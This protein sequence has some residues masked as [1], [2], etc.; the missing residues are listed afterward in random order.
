[1]CL[2]I[3]L[4]EVV[5]DWPLVIAANREEHYDRPGE[6]PRLLCESPL[7]FG[8]RDPRA[9]GT[10]LA[11]NQWAMVCAVTNRPRTEMRAGE[12]RSRGLL[13]LDAARQKS[14]IAV[15]DIIVRA[16]AQDRYDGFNLFCLTP[17]GGSAFYFDGRL[18]EKT[19]GAGP[20]VTT[21][22]DAND[23]SDPRVR[24]V[25]EMLDAGCPRPFPEWIERLEATCRDHRNDPTGR[26]GLCKH[27]ESAGTVSSTILAFH[28]RDPWIH[29]LRHCQGRPCQTPYETIAWPEDF[30]ATAS[31]ERQSG[32]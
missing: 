32:D 15:A 22:G 9:G 14:S 23:L 31:A 5:P 4:R 17:T 6:P 21:T 16:L 30:F 28:R 26:D 29:L 7:V 2:L 18:R 8:G 19:V 20:F 24:R 12:V 13:C 11:V 10:W 3:I 1:M 25:H 27:G